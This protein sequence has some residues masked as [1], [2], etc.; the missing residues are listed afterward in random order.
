MADGRCTCPA[1]VLH[2]PLKAEYFDAI[3]RGV[4]RHEY[5][6]DTEY[7]RKRLL[8]REYDYI[9]L[10]KGY[11]K[12]GDESRRIR[13]YWHGCFRKVHQHRHF[14]PSPVRVFVIPVHERLPSA[15]GKPQSLSE[16]VHASPEV[17][18]A[19]GNGVV[20]G[21]IAR[22]VSTTEGPGSLHAAAKSC[23]EGV[24]AADTSKHK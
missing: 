16:F 17:R 20:K 4:K 14:G 23:P 7:W 5:R 21:A 18:E 19:I 2:L 22:Q 1:R 15:I 13:C 9:E 3:L 11:P 24:E 6:L 8:N 12:K 10:T